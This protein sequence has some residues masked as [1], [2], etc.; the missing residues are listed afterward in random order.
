MSEDRI[1]GSSSSR[2]PAAGSSASTAPAVE[3]LSGTRGS[4]KSGTASGGATVPSTGTDALSPDPCGSGTDAQSPDPCG[5]GK[6]EK[7]IEATPQPTT[8]PAVVLATADAC[9]QSPR[10]DQSQASKSTS[11]DWSDEI[12]SCS[13]RG[14]NDT[15]V[16]AMDFE[17]T[18]K[19][20]FDQV[21]KDQV[22]KEPVSK[23]QMPK[24]QV[25]KEHQFNITTAVASM[26][27]EDGNAT[28][29]NGVDISAKRVSSKP[30]SLDMTNGTNGHT[31]DGT[32]PE[33]SIANLAAALSPDS[34]R[35]TSR[36]TSPGSRSLDSPK[37]VSARHGIAE[38]DLPED[39]GQTEGH[40]E[41][42]SGDD[43]EPC[44]AA[45]PQPVASEVPSP[46]EA[47]EESHENGQENS[48][49]PAKELPNDAPS[50]DTVTILVPDGVREDRLT[51]FIYAGEVWVVEVPEGTCAGDQVTVSLERGPLLYVRALQALKSGDLVC[52]SSMQREGSRRHI[53]APAFDPIHEGEGLGAQ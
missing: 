48:N 43:V 1:S 44:E 12:P 4:C 18:S 5:S 34:A 29:E 42:P 9:F 31:L 25:L 30:W 49:S 52:P 24:Q 51:R 6:L 17:D 33:L 32:V 36:G 37:P 22:V 50:S 35:G 46:V 53:W 15:R 28:S 19:I 14:S 45:S 40:A 7:Q 38:T 11:L 2:A 20:L 47:A 23:E 27:E 13:S 16:Y 39:R 21:F 8:A 26:T 10:V 3:S 41:Q